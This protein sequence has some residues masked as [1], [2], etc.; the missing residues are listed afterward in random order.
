VSE[1]RHPGGRERA[2]LS[3]MTTISQRLRGDLT[4]AMKARDRTAMAVLRSALAAIDN[5]EAVDAAG[6]APRRGLFANE[7]ARRHLTEDDVRAVLAAQHEELDLAIAELDRL[8]DSG[9]SIELRAQA[10][11]LDRYLT[12]PVAPRRP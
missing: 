5:A 7:A 10:A 1:H 6:S 4:T 8:G 11:V 2:I 3:A 12:D 9:R